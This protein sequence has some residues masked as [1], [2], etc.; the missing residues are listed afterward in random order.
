MKVVL[1]TMVFGAVSGAVRY[2]STSGGSAPSMTLYSSLEDDGV[3]SVEG[4]S[5]VAYNSYTETDGPVGT[6]YPWVTNGYVVEPHRVTTL[7]ST[8]T[9]DQTSMA[10]LSLS[11]SIDGGDEM[12]G[13]PVTYTF[14]NTGEYLVAMI[15][16]DQ[17]T[18]QIV[19]QEKMT[20]YCRYVRREI[21]GLT[22]EDREAF[23]EAAEVVYKTELTAG[24][25]KYGDNFLD[26]QWFTQLHNTLAG[27]RV[28]DHLHDGLGFLPQHAAFTLMFEKVLQLVNPVV[29]V[30]YWDY[31]IEAHAALVQGHIEAWRQSI[32]WDDDWF[33]EASPTDKV[34]TRGRF[35]L[36]PVVG[37]AWDITDTVNPYG[38]VRAPWNM[39]KEKYVTRHNYTYGFTLDD[40]PGC[41][42]HYDIMQ[43]TTWSD[44]GTNIAY[45]PHGTVH[46]MIGGVWGA[47]YHRKLINAGYSAIHAA[48]VGLEAFATQKNLWRAMQL[49]CPTYCSEE[50]PAHACKCTCPSITKWMGQ[51]WTHD[52]L[53]SVSPLFFT[54][55]YL[56]NT[57]KHD[58]S[59][60]ILKLMC[61]DYDEISPII[62]DSLESASPAD[63][64]FWPT[65][66]TVDRLYHWKKINGFKND[67]WI[68]NMAR[69][70]S[71]Q[72]VGYCWGHNLA[73]VTVW[74]N[75]FDN[76]GSAYSNEDLWTIFDSSKSTLMPYIYD[77]FQWKHCEE[78]G[79]P[80]QLFGDYTPPSDSDK[81]N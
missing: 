28:C 9:T 17:V 69:S 26:V 47:D 49:E 52:I 36:T 30:P 21:R 64:S 80:V 81:E 20:M 70:V 40:A 76:S 73:D 1:G 41:Q 58:I 16:R 79:Y 53:A 22:D 66:P 67:T 39:N 27:S 48:N 35:A 3:A 34:V 14:T 15:A 50:T 18:N 25:S 33:G 24:K 62:G 55:S 8:S 29:T 56:L 71:F 19:G 74:K 45:A 78:E 54:K 59:D 44:F 7:R 63:I 61:N 75:L 11:F 37:N 42:Q 12:E 43:E 77:N 38:F 4:L 10:R 32:V 5:F 72:N 65:H 31:T 13:S 46:A 6:D 23:F 51:G 60:M 2:S 68:D 57:N